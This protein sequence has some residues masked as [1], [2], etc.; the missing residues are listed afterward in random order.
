MPGLPLT[1]AR[2]PV[3]VIDLVAGAS[4]TV[5]SETAETVGAVVN[6]AGFG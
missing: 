3:I 6:E 4:P 2:E 1:V 5:I